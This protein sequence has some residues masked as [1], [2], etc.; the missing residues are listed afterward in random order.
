MKQKDQNGDRGGAT[1][2]S[3]IFDLA[4]DTAVPPMPKK[5][6]DPATAALVSAF[7]S[8]NAIIVQCC[9]SIRKGKLAEARDLAIQAR[10]ALGQAGNNLA[11]FQPPD[12]ELAGMALGEL[13]AEIAL[14]DE[15]SQQAIAAIDPQLSCAAASHDRLDSIGRRRDRLTAELQRRRASRRDRTA[16]A[17]E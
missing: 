14:L 16:K 8:V 13:R 3:A 1:L 5:P 6:L 11:I 12:E 15:Q 17:G 9:N 4:L 10:E 7:A 2:G